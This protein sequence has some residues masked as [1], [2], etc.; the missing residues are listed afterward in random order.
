M[1]AQ[2]Q[3]FPP[4]A[5]A[6]SPF[7][8]AS[9]RPHLNERSTY[10]PVGMQERFV[11]PVLARAIR[12][13]LANSMPEIR[14]GDRA[15]D[16]GCGRQPFR[17]EL[18]ALGL[19]YRGMDTQQNADCLVDIVAAI[20]GPIPAELRQLAPFRFILCTEVLEHVADWETTFKNF[21]KLLGPGGRVL[22]T[23]PFV[24]PLHEQPYDFW[25]PTIHAIGYFAMR[26]GFR[27]VDCS[28]AGEAWDV[29]GTVLASVRAA[30]RARGFSAWAAG[31]TAKAVKR[32]LYHA[33]ISQ[34]MR[35]LVN[36]EGEFYQSN[37]AVLERP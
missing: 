1:S 31:M 3:A 33:C 5:A 7:A 34:R 16:A 2:P 11:V 21:Q 30:P 10:E 8:G 23:A 36:L 32:V 25:R 4:D 27:V 18:E 24:Y 6:S 17:R 29:L 20:D 37:V 35:A 15:L 13:R 28:K 22:I 9:E 14:R 26:H 19:D 12:D